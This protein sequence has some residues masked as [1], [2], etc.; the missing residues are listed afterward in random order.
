M[1]TVKCV[2]PISKK[3]GNLK[4]ISSV[5]WNEDTKNGYPEL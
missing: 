4:N 1:A 2:K 5:E 3:A